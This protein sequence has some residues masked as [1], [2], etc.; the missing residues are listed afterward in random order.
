MPWHRLG[1]YK[2]DASGPFLF[3][4]VN[5]HNIPPT[6]YSIRL[7]QY[8]VYGHASYGPTFGAGHDIYVSTNSDKNKNNTFNFPHSYVDTTRRGQLT[9]TGE[10]KF[11]KQRNRSVSINLFQLTMERPI[12]LGSQ[13]DVEM[14]SFSI[15]YKYDQNKRR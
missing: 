12:L 15:L 5:P 7:F 11:P 1:C 4:L 13:R 14:R 9:F 2:S 3:T 8:A 6:K 10:N